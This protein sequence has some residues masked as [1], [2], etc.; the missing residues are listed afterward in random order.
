MTACEI[1]G[2]LKKADK[3]VENGVLYFLEVPRLSGTIDT[4]MVITPDDDLPEGEVHIK[5]HVE[6]A[7]MPKLGVPTFIVPH[8]VTPGPSDGVSKTV[9][10]GAIKEDPVVR[11]ARDKKTLSTILVTT[12]EGTIPVLLW[13]R[14]A[15]RA[16]SDFQAGDMVAVEGRLQSR[17][18][19]TR[20][21][22]R[23]TAYE[24]SAKTFGPA[25]ERGAL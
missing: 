14:N 5:G 2:V 1:N 4:L 12:D 8:T 21:G 13:G 9:I 11:A 25:G 20:A 15:S 7:W 23:R 17:E 19:S 16:E 3:K 18:Y 24:L 10:T 6:A 22:G